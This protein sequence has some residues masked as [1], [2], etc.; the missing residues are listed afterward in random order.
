MRVSTQQKWRVP[1]KLVEYLLS[2]LDFKEEK[3]SFKR[4][5]Y[6]V[7][8]SFVQMIEEN[9]QRRAEVDCFAS[10][11]NSQCTSYLT[12]KENALA[13]PWG[14]GGTVWLNPPWSLWPK[15]AKKLQKDPC[16]A[17][18]ILPDWNRGWVRELVRKATKKL[19]FPPGTKLFEVDGKPMGGVRWGVWALLIEGNKPPANTS[20]PKKPKV[21]H[22]KSRMVKKRYPPTG[23]EKFSKDRQLLIRTR[24]VLGNGEEQNLDILV[25]TG[26]E[27]N[28]IKQGLVSEHLMYSAEHP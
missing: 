2:A 14:G 23:I 28:L 21:V 4:E 18:C 27:A 16:D 22:L 24:V 15:V 6:A 7:R 9:F 8:N 13:V 20:N 5:D 11:Q 10:T 26:A 17:I 3:F 25:D 1:E 12:E 19:Y